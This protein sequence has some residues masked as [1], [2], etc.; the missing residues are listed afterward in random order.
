[1]S[2]ITNLFPINFI[3]DSFQ[4]KRVEYSAEKLK[5]L[6]KKHNSSHSFFR[7]ENYIYMSPMQDENL[8]IGEIV[9][10]SVQKDTKVISS[11]LKHVFFRK[12]REKYPGIIPLDF[13]PFRILSRKKED[14]LLFGQLPQHLQGAL[15]FK[16]LI[17][18]Q[19]RTVETN[20]KTQFG[21]VINIH[22]H[23][24][25]NK[26]CKQLVDEGFD[27]AGLSVL[28][29]EAIPGLEGILAPDESLVG[30]VKQIQKNNVIIETNNGE[31]N[32]DLEDLYLHRS[33]YNIRKYI[34]FKLGRTKAE[35]IF[36]YLREK[37][38]S[39]LSAKV[40]FNEVK[41]LSKNLSTIDF[42]NQDGFSFSI[43]NLSQVA[44]SKFSIQNPS[45]IFDYNPGATH[46]NPSKGLVNFGPY[47][48]STFD[49]KH[50][51]IL[52]V[53]TKTNRGA[54]AE[55]LGKLKQ[56]IPSSAFFK[57]GMVGK[58][59]LHDISFHI[60]ELD[61]YSVNEYQNKIIEYV[62]NLSTLP[63]MAIIETMEMFKH[64]TPDNNPYYQA[65]AYFLGLGIPVQ[66]VKNENIR[67]PDNSLQWTIDSI[68]LQI[69]AKLGGKPW[70][71]PSSSSID[72]EI[73]I[74]IGST[75]LR[76]NLLFGS[77]QERVVGITTFFTGDGRYIFG[78]RCKDVPFDEYFNELLS[79][80]RQSIKDISA[81]YGWKEK[82]TI[83]ITFH[84]FKPIKNIEAD[85]IEELLTEFQQYKIQYCF[86]T[87]SD[88]HPYLL[89]DT[90][91]A[92][93][94]ENKKGEFVPERGQNWIIDEYSCL[95]QLKGPQE[96]KT[97]KH[98]FS[99]PILIRIHEKST[100]RDLNTVAQQIFN[101]T[102]L[103][104]RGFH[105]THQPVTILYSD[106]IA[107]QLANLRK[108]SS[109]KPETVNSLL[110]S[111]KWFL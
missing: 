100:Y 58:Y 36:N 78:N 61:N 101:F 76:H 107:K 29:S 77:F 57:G 104:W 2:L 3:N 80:L 16:K 89:F 37:D 90:N 18:I 64:E 49:I 96:M 98:G 35:Y 99:N 59:R 87:V 70:V 42:C 11:L 4:I 81:E 34:E 8:D 74:G 105:A 43:S 62:K 41:E 38:K 26:T 85:V 40:Y 51:Q 10:I 23:W 6:R 12:F 13:Y 111:K 91:Q 48:S 97:S 68:A 33:T 52:V 92:G 45:F 15:S 71:L 55:F 72:N 21:A 73:I 88:S 9:T 60:I 31:E 54:F 79:S 46:D 109:W 83:R 106:L 24:Q 67:K 47:D 66:F 84:V 110:R 102:N 7:N 69:Y 75:L 82:S 94:G 17:E 44:T 20:Q 1:M 30:I 56:G 95:L 53:C 65:R 93:I 32:F 27:I 19:F 28:T 25:F 50:P 22:Y 5:E 39:R 103:S 63:N 86:V 14:D 108:I